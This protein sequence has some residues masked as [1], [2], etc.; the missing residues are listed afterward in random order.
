MT[1]LIDKFKFDRSVVPK[2]F[3]TTERSMLDNFTT[4]QRDG[5]VG[6]GGVYVDC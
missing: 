2:L 5:G 4:D 6:V 3:I 1:E